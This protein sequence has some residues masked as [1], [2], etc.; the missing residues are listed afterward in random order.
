MPYLGGETAIWVGV[1]CHG[2]VWNGEHK[3]AKK[4]PDANPE[5]TVRDQEWEQHNREPIEDSQ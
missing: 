5:E 2:R 3:A 4:H 1:I